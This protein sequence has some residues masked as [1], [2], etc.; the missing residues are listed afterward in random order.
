MGGWVG[1]WPGLY[2]IC[3]YY[4]TVFVYKALYTKSEHERASL[5]VLCRTD[6]RSTC[7]AVTETASNTPVHTA[8]SSGTRLS[9]YMYEDRVSIAAA[10]GKYDRPSAVQTS[11]YH[12][13]T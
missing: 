10:V 8:V 4:R 3:F 2:P 5:A 9:R 6:G 7:Q 1:G 13:E 12:R 11:P